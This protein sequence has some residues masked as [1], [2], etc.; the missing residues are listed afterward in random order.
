MFVPISAVSRVQA[1]NRSRLSNLAYLIRK[2][3][4]SDRAIQNMVK[5]TLALGRN[6][7]RNICL[8]RLYIENFVKRC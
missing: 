2:L 4:I 5:V 6:L 1:K 7:K 3:C 8:G